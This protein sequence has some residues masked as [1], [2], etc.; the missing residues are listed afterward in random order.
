MPDRA[1]TIRQV[2]QPDGRTE[3]VATISETKIVLIATGRFLSRDS[4]EKFAARSGA[5]VKGTR[6]G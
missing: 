2:Q 3:Y 4:A 1:A 5:V 6:D